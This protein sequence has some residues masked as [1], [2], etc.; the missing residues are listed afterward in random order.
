MSTTPLAR[1]GEFGNTTPP[2]PAKQIPAA[3][4]AMARNWLETRRQAFPTFARPPEFVVVRSEVT[5]TRY[6]VGWYLEVPAR[7]LKENR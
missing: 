2:V 5:G 7:H 3:L 6:T 1:P 4:E